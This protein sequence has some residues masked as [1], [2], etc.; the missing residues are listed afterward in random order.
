ME[1]IQVVPLTVI[2]RN[3]AKQGF[4]AWTVSAERRH[5]EIY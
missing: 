4:E 2:L 1:F 5:Y 3:Y